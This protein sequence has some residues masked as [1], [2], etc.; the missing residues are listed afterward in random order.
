MPV[1]DFGWFEG[2][3]NLL[4][5][6]TRRCLPRRPSRGGWRGPRGAQPSQ[7]WK[8]MRRAPTSPI[9]CA[10]SAIP[11]RFPRIA[12]KGREFHRP[13]S[14]AFVRKLGGRIDMATFAREKDRASAKV[15]SP[16]DARAGGADRFPSCR[17]KR[18]FRSPSR[19]DQD[20]ARERN[21]RSSP[22][23]VSAGWSEARYEILNLKTSPAL[24]TGA[25][26][27]TAPEALS[28]LKRAMAL[29]PSLRVLVAHGLT[30]QVTPILASKVLID[31]VPPMGDPEPPAPQGLWRRPHAAL[32]GRQI[33]RRLAGRRAEIDRGGLGSVDILRIE[34]RDSPLR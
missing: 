23:I 2:A 21:G 8:P 5:F 22:A 11:R 31:Q 20:P 18:L 6:A 17:R 3:N 29:D 24:G 13:R 1:L 30:D 15:T 27:A 32:S 12:E 16:Y 4:T 7:M 14:G 26:A 33:P 19:R 25:L 28:D 9:S 34:G 10:A